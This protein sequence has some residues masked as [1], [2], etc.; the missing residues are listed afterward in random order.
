MNLTQLIEEWQNDA[1]I[2]RLDLIGASLEIPNLHA[3][4]WRL[5]MQERAKLIA[6]MGE[7]KT[8][9]MDKYEFYVEGP[10]SETPS[11]WE[12]P[13]RGKILKADVE[14]YLDADKHIITLAQRVDLQKEKIKMI[15]GIIYHINF[16]SNSIKNAIEM[17]K[18]EAGER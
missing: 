15:E 2:N 16:R 18:F 11:E 10:N 9:K 1:E 14:R 17:I 4:Y 8:L 3:K 6:W 12:F 7:L 13:A 5:Y